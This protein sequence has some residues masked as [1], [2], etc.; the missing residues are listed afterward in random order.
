[1]RGG[2]SVLQWGWFCRGGAYLGNV[3]L[4]PSGCCL[5]PW[6]PEEAAQAGTH[7]A[8]SQRPCAVGHSV[9]CRSQLVHLLR[10]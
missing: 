5:P 10:H 3:L 7:S 1:M 2:L 6:P 9:P 8:S 4:R